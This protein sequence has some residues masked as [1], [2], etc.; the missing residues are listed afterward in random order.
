MPIILR[1][2]ELEGLVDM[3]SAIDA[4]CEAYRGATEFPVINAP[5]RRV[6][7]PSGVRISNFPGGVHALGVIGSGTRAELVRQT[8][9][10]QN[11]EFREHPVHV[12]HDS[13]TARLLAI[14]LG[15]VTEKT[16][17]PSSLMAFRTAA[18]S[19]VGFRYLVR[20]DAKSAGLFGSGG[21]AAYQ[22][23]ALLTERPRSRRS[24]STAAIRTT[25][26]PLR[27]G[28]PRRSASKSSRSMPRAPSWSR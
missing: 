7:S 13:R 15:E 27:I 3:K 21:Q 5:R 1:P 16:L 14:V 8:E 26:A 25:A 10:N 4:V 20:D 22:L 11:Y 17:G 9:G 18:T 2:Q 28:I 12:L 24:A 23:L 6:H 19:G